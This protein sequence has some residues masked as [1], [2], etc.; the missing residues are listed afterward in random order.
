[1][2]TTVADY[3]LQRLREW[4]RRAR[5][6]VSRR[7][8][9]R[10][11][12]RVLPGGRRPAVHP[13][14]AR[15]DERAPGGRLRQVQRPPR[16][17][18]GDLR[19]RRHPPAQRPV[20][21]EARP[22]ARRGDRRGRPT[23]PRWAA[24]TSRRSTCSAC[25][26]TSP[27]TTSRWS[28]SP[29]SC[30][31]CS[32]GRSGPPMSQAGAHRDHHPQRRPGAGVHP[33]RRTSSRW[34]P[35]ASA[36]DQPTVARRRELRSVAAADLLNAG[37]KVAMLVGQGARAAQREVE[38]VADLLGA[39]VAKALLGKDVPQRRAAVRHR[40]HRA[41]RDPAQLRDDAR[42]RHPAHRGVELPLHPV[43]AATWTRPG[44][45]RST[46][47]ASLIGMRYPYEVNLV[48]D[49][50]ATLRALI[51]AAG[52]QGGPLLAGGHHRPA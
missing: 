47:T 45:S 9:Q 41:A 30:R 12:R 33:T 6:R 32:T 31:T 49:A 25:S 50:A 26:R 37:T 42:L 44:P 28:T 21:R 34:C 24:A 2:T 35:R 14:A 39:G 19:A 8:H 43:P 16:R 7:R 36:L 1:M 22:R 18:P 40:L 23:A 51:P 46:S 15:G 11:P 3:L 13:G 29:S 17:L 38:Q 48:G 10:D 4:E 20:R 5:V 27:A 52:A